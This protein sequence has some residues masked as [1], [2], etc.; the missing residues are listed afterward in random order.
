MDLT[1]ISMVLAA[2]AAIVAILRWL[3]GEDS[4]YKLLR[5]RGVFHS[6]RL[7]KIKYLS[8]TDVQA[9]QDRHPD[10][11]PDTMQTEL[12][13]CYKEGDHGDNVLA[14]SYVS[15][16]GPAEIPP[17]SFGGPLHALQCRPLADYASKK[18]NRKA[19]LVY[20]ASA[21]VDVSLGKTRGF[22]VRI[23]RWL[24]LYRSDKSKHFLVLL[25][26]GPKVRHM[27][28]W[29]DTR[30][31]IRDIVTISGWKTDATDALRLVLQE[32]VIPSPNML[33][34]RMNNIADLNL[35]TWILAY[36]SHYVVSAK[37]N[38]ILY[39]TRKVARDHG[40]LHDVDNKEGQT[41]PVMRQSIKVNRDYVE[42]TLGREIAVEFEYTH[43]KDFANGFIVSHIFTRSKVFFYYDSKDASFYGHPTRATAYANDGTTVLAR[44]RLLALD[45]KQFVIQ[46]VHCDDRGQTTYEGRL[47][48]PISMGFSNE[49]TPISG[50]KRY[51]YFFFWPSGR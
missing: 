50:A 51:E 27:I 31:S 20:V 28:A 40:Y 32:G 33:I 46:E 23:H 9:F 37:D 26:A 47:A 5:L 39:D 43:E 30:C 13:Y 8:T 42:R 4:F 21:A 6:A 38:S 11:S 45:Q 25:E 2:V 35:P 18:W 10:L 41:V 1:T 17:P 24:F 29:S 22:Y 3:T 48:V 49:S 7:P 12:S 44:A 34:L 36:N 16:F 14:E 15:S 19:S